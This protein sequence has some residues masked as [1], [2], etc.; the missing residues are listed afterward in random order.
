MSDEQDQS[1]PEVRFVPLPL[2]AMV[3]L[4]EHDLP[5]ASAV[6]GV[7][8]TEFLHQE[9]W[10]W[11]IRAEQI[12]RDPGSAEW[13]ARAAVVEGRVVGHGGFHGPPDAD[14][15][16]EVAYSVDPAYRRRGHATAMLAALIE[17]CRNDPRVRVVRA[18]ISPDNA[19]SLAT[20]ARFDFVS[21]GQQW[22]EEDGLELL[23]ELPVEQES[24]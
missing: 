23:F 5:R 6:A 14:G 22:D 13:V 20:L 2:A 16:V 11:Q 7:E 17:R 12:V 3:A 1:R 4:L 10:L 21:A 18:S 19:A 8:L 15:M 24:S 9:N